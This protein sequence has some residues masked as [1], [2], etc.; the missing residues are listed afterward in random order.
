MPVQW[1]VAFTL[2]HQRALSA[3]LSWKVAK[4]SRPNKMRA[5]QIKGLHKGQ[6]CRGVKGRG[7]R[8]VRAGECSG[9]WMPQLLSCMQ[10][11]C[12]H[13]KRCRRKKNERTWKKLLSC[14]PSVS[15]TPSTSAIVPCICQLAT[16]SIEI[17]V[18]PR[19]LS[20]VLV[21]DLTFGKSFLISLHNWYATL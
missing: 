9:G 16:H 8:R 5:K 12:Q 18:E 3:K 15:A 19:D 21:G 1:H 10:K 17:C 14:P 20:D 2:P 11:S 13:V 6:T 4:E 7:T